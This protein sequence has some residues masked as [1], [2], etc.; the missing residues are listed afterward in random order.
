M[1]AQGARQRLVSGGGSSGGKLKSSYKAVG[2]H[3]K[4]GWGA[5]VGGWKGGRGWYWGCGLAFWQSCRLLR[6]ESW[7][8]Q[9][10]SGKT[11]WRW[12]NRIQC[13]SCPVTMLPFPPS[14]CRAQAV[15][16]SASA[17]QKHPPQNPFKKSHEWLSPPSWG[18]QG[19][20]NDK[21][22]GG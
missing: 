15:I 7:E 11:V 14:N 3:C 6:P 22:G 8:G 19:Q 16:K 21:R 20:E 18:E 12:G 5:V 17:V 10:P 4:I 1:A 2:A 9:C 13:G